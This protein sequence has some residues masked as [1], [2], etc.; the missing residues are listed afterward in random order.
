MLIILTK[1]LY[2]YMQD[3]VEN[4]MILTSSR[5]ND[6]KHIFSRISHVALL[7]SVVIGVGNH[8]RLQLMLK[9][10]PTLQQHT[11]STKGGIFGYLWFKPYFL[12]NKTIK[13][14]IANHCKKNINK[15]DL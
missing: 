3:R 1:I 15:D 12:S 13:V 8:Q 4:Q 6:F 2:Q 14:K 7:F 9:Y 5:E 10:I 11:H